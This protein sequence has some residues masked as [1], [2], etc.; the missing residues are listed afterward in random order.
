MSDRHAEKVRA[1]KQRV[2][3]ELAKFRDDTSDERLKHL[4][5]AI[6]HWRGVV[7]AWSGTN[8]VESG[9]QNLS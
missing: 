4:Q 8:P 7:G 9:K 5:T 3:D 1:A 2:I 6:D